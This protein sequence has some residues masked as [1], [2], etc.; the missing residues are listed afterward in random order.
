MFGFVTTKLLAWCCAGL[1]A[2]L[3]VTGAFA[4]CEHR[5]ANAARADRDAMKNERNTAR[6]DRDRVV[7]S[8]ETQQALIVDLNAALDRWAEI[9]LT[10]SEV[11]ELSA[12]AGAR[13][14]ALDELAAENAK[15]KGKDDGNPDCEKLRQV[16]F[17]RVCPNRARSLRRYEDRLPRRTGRGEGAGLRGAAGGTT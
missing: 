13:Q 3:L 4:G 12:E 11:R 16:D 15:L 17:Q 6:D 14:R 1:L 2:A 8:N 7:K 10:P 5:N 9:G